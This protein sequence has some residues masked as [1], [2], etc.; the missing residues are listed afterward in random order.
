[1]SESRAQRLDDALSS[2]VDA[3]LPADLDDDEA[4]ADQRHENAVDL[5]KSILDRSVDRL[6]ATSSHWLM[7]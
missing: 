4:L 6:S 1:M 2:L 3:F 7:R 5:A